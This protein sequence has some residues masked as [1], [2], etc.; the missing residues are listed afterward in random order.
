VNSFLKRN[1]HILFSIIASCV[2]TVFLSSYLFHLPN[3]SKPKPNSNLEQFYDKKNSLEK[4]NHQGFHIVLSTLMPWGKDIKNKLKKENNASKKDEPPSSAKFSG[5]IQAGNE[6]YLIF[7]DDKSKKTFRY[8]IQQQL[9]DG[10][11]IIEINA[12]SFTVYTDS[13][14]KKLTKLYRN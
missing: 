13:S 14:N 7:F 10:S 3:D 12:D 4:K 2:C 9:P 11:Q 8:K 1:K 5:I 6:R